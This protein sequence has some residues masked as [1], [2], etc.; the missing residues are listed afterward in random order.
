MKCRSNM[1]HSLMKRAT[2][3]VEEA[4]ARLGLGRSAAYAAVK[5]GDIP[6]LRIGGK[7]IVPHVLLE[8]L[9]RGELARQRK[10]NAR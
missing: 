2:Y 9:L 10:A 6:A 3:S 4:G 1:G 7:W 8:Q 5:R